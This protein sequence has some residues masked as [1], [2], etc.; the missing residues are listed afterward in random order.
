MVNHNSFIC[1]E[2]KGK[3][4]FLKKMNAIQVLALLLL[5]CSC[6]GQERC[7][8]LHPLPE[9]ISTSGSEV[10]NEVLEILECSGVFF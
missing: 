6:L 7:G 3:S 5:V 10:V 2:N 9:G 8:L 1:C 4:L